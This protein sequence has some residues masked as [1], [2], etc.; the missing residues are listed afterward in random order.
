[1]LFPYKRDILL[2]LT[3]LGLRRF[4]GSPRVLMRVDS[5]ICGMIYVLLAVIPVAFLLGWLLAKVRYTAA[6]A[7]AEADV[8]AQATRLQAQ[9]AQVGHLQQTFGATFENLANRIFDQK[10]AKFT[11]LNKENMQAMLDPLGKS[12]VEFKEQVRQAYVSESKERFSLGER[13]KELALLNQQLSQEAHN[14]TRALKGESKTQGRWGEMILETILEKSG[15]RKGEEYFMEH[16]LYDASGRPLKNE[17]TGSRLRPDA[18]VKYPDERHVIIDA[19]VSLNA[20]IRYTETNDPLELTAHVQA[21][22]GHIQELNA[23]AYD[24]YHKSLDFVMMFIPNE[25][26][27]IAGLQKDPELWSY[28]YDKRILLVNP[29]SLIVSLKL[30]LDLWKREYQNRNAQDIADRGGRLYDKFV[31]FVTNLQRV[32]TALDVAQSA[33]GDAFKQLSTGKDNLVQQAGKLKDLGVKAKNE[34]PE[35]LRDG[36]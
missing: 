22:K 31:G 11:Q 28:A 6:L 5:V 7:K 15:L 33:Y 36:E 25:A 26:A 24:D 2:I 27:Y 21:I 34:L 1:M 16:Q 3:F 9:E 17:F 29:T 4:T 13:V 18:L 12:I 8:Q 23:R 20:F 19:K 32:G 35:G 14:L 10:T 30:I